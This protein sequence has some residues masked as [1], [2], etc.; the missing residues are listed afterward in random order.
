MALLEQT[1]KGLPDIVYDRVSK[2]KFNGI[3]NNLDKY[4]DWY[5]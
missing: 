1:L 4:E 2:E 3:I 5:V